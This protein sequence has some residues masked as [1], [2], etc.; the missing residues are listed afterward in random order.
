ME[1]EVVEARGH[2]LAGVV[3]GNKA[4]GHSVFERYTEAARRAIFY[5][6]AEALGRNGEIITVADLLAGLSLSEDTRAQRVGS[7]K[8]NG[9]YLRWLSGLPALPSTTPGSNWRDE[10]KQLE[11]DPEARQTLAF[12]L[13]EAN[14]DREYWIDTDHLLRGLLRFPNRANFAMLKTEINLKS[15]RIASRRDREK[16]LPD[17]TPS[18]KVMRYLMRKHFALWLPAVLTLACYLYILM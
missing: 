6:R 1:K 3:T 18:L 2:M 14:R 9:F 5:A 17:E 11:L 12:A 16:F 13:L 4:N 7:L 8:D 10:T 15:A